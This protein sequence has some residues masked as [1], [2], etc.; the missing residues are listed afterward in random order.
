MMN[1]E[2]AACILVRLAC[3][4][5]G[6][7]RMAL[8]EI[9][10]TLECPYCSTEAKFEHLGTGQTTRLLPYF[11]LEANLQQFRTEPP[12]SEGHPRLHRGQL[13]IY[14]QELSIL[15][16]A[17]VDEIWTNAVN[18]SPAGMPS[19]S[20]RIAGLDTGPV[21]HVS[22]SDG[23]PP[24]W[25]FPEDMRKAADEELKSRATSG[26]TAVASVESGT[27]TSYNLASHGTGYAGGTPQ[28]DIPPQPGK[29]AKKR[30]AKKSLR[31]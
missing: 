4:R 22:G 30:A 6:P 14:C 25:C 2:P 27:V 11:E 1:R 24:F 18:V 12:R 9:P 19:I 3:E 31:N 15:H 8:A 7:V 20:F 28:I 26:L 13:V 29:Q 16:F 21:P 10:E 23:V 17:T 5:C